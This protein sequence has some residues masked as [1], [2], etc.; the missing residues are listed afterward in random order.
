MP[1]EDG[2]GY[3]DSTP[4]KIEHL[5]KIMAMHLN[6]SWAV[7]NRGRSWANRSYHYMD[8]T[9]GKG[10]T[11]D[12]LPGSPLVLLN[13]INELGHT[14]PFAMDFIERESENI[15]Q[16]ETRIADAVKQLRLTDNS[17]IRFHNNPYEEIIPQLMEF[18]DSR[19]F[20][21]AFVDPSGNAPH[22]ESLK[23]ISE[24]RPK[25][26]ILI[27]VSATNIKRAY[28]YSGMHLSDYMAQ[29]G[30][31]YWIVRK[32]ISWDAHKFTF[33][34]GSNT[35]LFK[36]YRSIDFYRLDSPEGEEIFERLEYTRD[37]LQERKQMRFDFLDDE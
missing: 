5:K 26:E 8:L 34:L 22:L 3:S 1:L 32:P 10:E 11:P 7:I 27:Y 35:E 29:V 17:T 4:R 36:N 6:I 21:L 15:G 30:K 12:G 13:Q 18:G 37:E 9:A 16:L 2:I 28:Q 33:L 24:K 25:M 19:Q 20:G 31:R 23:L 14:G